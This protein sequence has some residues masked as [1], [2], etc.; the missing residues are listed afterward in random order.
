VKDLF[1]GTRN[2]TLLGIRERDGGLIVGPRGDHELHEGDIAIVL[3]DEADIAR[4][5]SP[6]GGMVGV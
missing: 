1:A 6:D 4:L 2:A 3:A 5:V